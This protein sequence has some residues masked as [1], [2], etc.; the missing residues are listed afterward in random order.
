MAWICHWNVTLLLSLVANPHG[1]ATIDVDI[2]YGAC[3]IA[4]NE[5]NGFV[6]QSVYTLLPIWDSLPMRSSVSFFYNHKKIKVKM[7]RSTSEKIA[8]KC[9]CRHGI[10]NYLS[11]QTAIR[12][13]NF[14][15]VFDQQTPLNRIFPQYILYIYIPYIVHIHNRYFISSRLRKSSFY[16]STSFKWYGNMWE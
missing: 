5:K 16:R 13:C 12:D 14:R 9:K 2:R 15:P 3:N 4:W 1:K 6:G 7:L 8:E 11:N 10:L